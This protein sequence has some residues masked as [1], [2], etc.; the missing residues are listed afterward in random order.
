MITSSSTIMILER[1]LIRSGAFPHL[2]RMGETSK[3]QALHREA[4]SVPAA[5]GRDG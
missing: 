1:L 2:D 5:S 4:P 3:G